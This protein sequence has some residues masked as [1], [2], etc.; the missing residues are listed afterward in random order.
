MPFMENPTFTGRE[1]KRA[2]SGLRQD[3]DRLSKNVDEDVTQAGALV[4]EVRNALSDLMKR[5]TTPD[6]A[7]RLTGLDRAY[8]GFQRVR[9]ASEAGREGL[10]TPFQYS[11]AIKRAERATGGRGFAR[12]EGLGQELAEAGEEVISSRVPDSGTPERLL[13]PALVGGAGYIDPTLAAGTA[14]GIAPYTRMGQNILARLA[15]RQPS[16]GAQILAENLRRAA[17]PIAIGAAA[18]AQ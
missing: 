1:V 3:A 17:A 13:A 10:F 9:S 15:M 4:R 18:G 11:Q 7:A 14:V 5:N 2:I 12:G 16:Q 6:N 8:A